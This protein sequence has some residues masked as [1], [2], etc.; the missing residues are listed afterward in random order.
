MEAVADGHDRASSEVTA[1]RDKHGWLP[2]P[3]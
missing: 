3:G 1:V 2:L